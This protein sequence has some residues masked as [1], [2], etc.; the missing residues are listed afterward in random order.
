MVLPYH[1][2]HQPR[3]EKTEL[4][5]KHPTR[6]CENKFNHDKE[7]Q[8]VRNSER[9]IESLIKLPGSHKEIMREAGRIAKGPLEVMLRC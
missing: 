7:E 4:S 2:I 9:A 5:A 3:Q 6:D 8:P 1:D